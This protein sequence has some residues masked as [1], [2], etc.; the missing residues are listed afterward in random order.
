MS[1][2]LSRFAF[3]APV[4]LGLLSLSMWPAQAAAP[5][6][7]FVVMAGG[8]VV[9]TKTNLTW[10]QVTSAT[11]YTWSNAGFYCSGN[12]PGLPGTGWRL[13]EIKELLSL[14]DDRASVAP[15]IDT[16]AFPGT[17]SAAYW[18]S[19]RVSTDVADSWVVYFD[20]GAAEG[21]SLPTTNYVRCVR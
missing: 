17:Q 5:A 16:A 2:F 21:N 13:P 8:I 19:T 6:G 11:T 20:S 10:Q 14:V 3:A 1:P 15:T 12:T 7:H 9:D 4:G 18:S